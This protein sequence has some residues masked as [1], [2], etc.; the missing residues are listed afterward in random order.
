MPVADVHRRGPVL[1]IILASYLMIVLDISIVITA[2]PRIRDG[3][4]FSAT[5]LALA[6]ALVIALIVRPRATA[7]VAD[8][9]PTRP[10]SV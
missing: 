8:D 2:L 3:L 5:M 4:D 7:E 1:A 6:L 10:A 9:P